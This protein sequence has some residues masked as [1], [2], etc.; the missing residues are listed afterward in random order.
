[1]MDWFGYLQFTFSSFLVNMVVVAMLLAML[2]MAV[3]TLFVLLH[4]KEGP[5]IMLD[6][7]ILAGIFISLAATQFG[8]IPVSFNGVAKLG[9]VTFPAGPLMSVYETTMGYVLGGVGW[10]STLML[11]IGGLMVLGSRG[12]NGMTLFLYGVLM[13]AIASL[14][15]NGGII[16]LIMNYIG[17]TAPV[18]A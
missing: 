15:G 10:L 8:A 4:K 7:C 1:M 5:T 9:L 12:G 11:G 6:G 18:I 3:G 2:V 14:I 13:A 16:T 17:V